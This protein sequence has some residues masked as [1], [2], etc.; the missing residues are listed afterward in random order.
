MFMA[1]LL[2]LY[3]KTNYP[4]LRVRKQIEDICSMCYIFQNTHKYVKRKQRPAVPPDSKNNNPQAENNS[5]IDDDDSIPPFLVNRSRS[6]SKIINHNAQEDEDEDVDQRFLRMSTQT[7]L[8]VKLKSY[9]L[10]STL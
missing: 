5:N 8:N 2:L 10:Q 9:K 1:E 3:W 6:T 7:L 4:K